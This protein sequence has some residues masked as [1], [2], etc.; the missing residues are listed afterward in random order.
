MGELNSDMDEEFDGVNKVQ[1]WLYGLTVKWKRLG[2][3]GKAWRL[4]N[5]NYF[6]EQSSC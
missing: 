1:S 2:I 5:D 4:C 6:I 3:L